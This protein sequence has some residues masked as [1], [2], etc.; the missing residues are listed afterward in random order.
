VGAAG[1]AWRTA[2]WNSRGP[3][4]S[5]RRE[6]TRRMV[7]QR[8]TTFTRGTGQYQPW[9]DYRPEPSVTTSP[10]EGEASS[11]SR[12][13]GCCYRRD[14]VGKRDSSRARPLRTGTS[15]SARCF[16]LSRACRNAGLWP[17]IGPRLVLACPTVNVV[18]RCPPSVELALG[19]VDPKDTTVPSRCPPCITGCTHS[20]RSQSGSAASALARFGI[21]GFDVASRRPLAA[22]A[23]GRPRTAGDAL[24]L[25][26]APLPVE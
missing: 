3:S 19:G 13:A 7:V 8:G 22:F 4:G 18:P 21:E 20:G 5:T 11:G 25:H 26:E 1:D 23:D 12:C 9:A 2:A 10:R 24:R 14:G 15:R 16:A 6:P 17:I